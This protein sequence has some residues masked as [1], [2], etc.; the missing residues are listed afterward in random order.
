VVTLDDNLLIKLTW[1]YRQFFK[2]QVC[3]SF[4]LTHFW[5]MYASWWMPRIRFEIHN[6][7]TLYLLN[8]L[9]AQ[10]LSFG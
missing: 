7:Y 9:Y 10:H 5:L 8:N 6:M 3:V 1:R 2:D 4:L